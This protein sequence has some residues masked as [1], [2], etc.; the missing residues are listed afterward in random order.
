MSVE[1]W[2]G[3]GTAVWALI[4][5]IIWLWFCWYEGTDEPTNDGILSPSFI[6]QAW[7]LV[8]VLFVFLGAMWMVF[9]P[10]FALH[11]KVSGFVARR[12]FERKK[13]G[14][15]NSHEGRVVEEFAVR[16]DQSP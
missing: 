4:A 1:L 9:Y 15:A 14:I 16:K 10:F 13:A 3:C 12:G 8:L 7:P 5:W 11:W 6:A 2:L